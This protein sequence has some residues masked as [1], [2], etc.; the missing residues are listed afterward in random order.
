MTIPYPIYQHLV[1]YLAD[2]NDSP[3]TEEEIESTIIGLASNRLILLLAKSTSKDAKFLSS[4]I[5][6]LS[7]KGHLSDKQWAAVE[8]IETQYGIDY[9]GGDR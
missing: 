2:I 3:P 8:K 4:L 1:A 5:E 7:T 9:W 6:Q